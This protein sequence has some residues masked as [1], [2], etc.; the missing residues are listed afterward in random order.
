MTGPDGMYCQCLCVTQRRSVLSPPH[1]R[2]TPLIL[3]PVAMCSFMSSIVLTAALLIVK[4]TAQDDT[5]VVSKDVV[6]I[7][8]GA[9]G[10]HAA[11]RLR[12]DLDQDIILIEKKSILVRSCSCRVDVGN[13]AS[14]SQ[15]DVLSPGRPC[16]QLYRPGYRG[17][18]RL[19][20]PVFQ[21]LRQGKGV[22]R[23]TGRRDGRTTTV[24]P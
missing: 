17:P 9:S 12:E 11:V 1:L 23:E 15:T 6:I 7:G 18:L 16:R 21:R 5:A 22:L 24:Q 20:R 4:G 13:T 8:G 14:P 10:A 3:L 2:P 19:W